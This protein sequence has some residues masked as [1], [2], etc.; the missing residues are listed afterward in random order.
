MTENTQI[1]LT[2]EEIR[3]RVESTNRFTREEMIVYRNQIAKTRKAR[4]ERLHSKST[5]EQV[6]IIA[7]LHE[8]GYTQLHDVKRKVLKSG[9]RYVIELAKPKVNAKSKI[10]ALEAELAKYRAL[11]AKTPAGQQLAAINV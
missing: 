6:A 11:F 1:T 7:S 8:D 4:R 3:T 10:E 9:D 5:N 2:T